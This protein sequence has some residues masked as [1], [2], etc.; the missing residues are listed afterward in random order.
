MRRAAADNLGTPGNV[1]ILIR[2]AS[3][4]FLSG[5]AP[6]ELGSL[7]ENTTP[8]DH[9][10]LGSRRA[11]TGNRLESPWLFYHSDCGR[12]TKQG[13]TNSFREIN[14]SRSRIKSE[15]D[16]AGLPLMFSPFLPLRWFRSCCGF[17]LFINIYNHQCF[18]STHWSATSTG[19][20]TYLSI[21][22]WWLVLAAVVE[23]TTSHT[24]CGCKMTAAPACHSDSLHSAAPPSQTQF[25][26]SHFMVEEMT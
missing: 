5:N 6:L 14:P 26:S 13:F 25:L 18:L 4:M 3:G 23:V 17:H 10:S 22:M 16:L 20:Q 7:I 11:F 1:N 2:S 12:T 15:P 21:G 8:S 24:V 9:N 19:A